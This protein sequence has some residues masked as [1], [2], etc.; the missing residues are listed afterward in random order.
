MSKRIIIPLL[1]LAF[2]ACTKEPQ[3]QPEEK[4]YDFN[5][6]RYES[7]AYHSWLPNERSF[8]AI[9]FVTE[10]NFQMYNGFDSIGL[11]S[12]WYRYKIIGSPKTYAYKIWENGKKPWLWTYLSDNPFDIDEFYSSYTRHGYEI[13]TSETF[14]YYVNEFTDRVYERVQ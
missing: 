9:D 11:D 7:Y 1:C 4:T 2:A 8:F 12:V 3:P 5:G 10:Y 13:D 14:I 6:R